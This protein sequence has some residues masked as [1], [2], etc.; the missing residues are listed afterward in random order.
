MLFV[1][2]LGLSQAKRVYMHNLFGTDSLR[3]T[4]HKYFGLPL[5]GS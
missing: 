4:T 5:A 3:D 1:A 2:S